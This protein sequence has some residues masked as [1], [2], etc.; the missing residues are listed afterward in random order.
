MKQIV[1]IIRAQAIG[2][3][4]EALVN[5]GVSGFTVRK[6]LG[7][8]KARALVGAAAGRFEPE[9][10]SDEAARLLPKR[11]LSIVVP[12]ERVAAVVQTIIDVNRSGKPGDGKLFVVPVRETIRI[13]SGE[14]GSRA[15][16]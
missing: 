13:R 5:A 11:M 1:A 4:R 2:R 15:L 7:R 3:T 10:P 9:P 14:T 6:V 16:E 8:G 12:D